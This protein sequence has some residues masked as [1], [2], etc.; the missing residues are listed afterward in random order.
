[1]LELESEKEHTE[2]MLTT[3]K[4]LKNSL[5]TD[6]GQ[7]KTRNDK[8]EEHLRKLEIQLSGEVRKREVAEMPVRQLKEKVEQLRSELDIS[9]EW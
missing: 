1:M 7:E 5:L 9:Y 4:R 8:F 6:L 2:T 3:G